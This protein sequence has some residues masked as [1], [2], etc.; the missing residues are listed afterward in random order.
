MFDVMLIPSDR[1]TYTLSSF[2]T[3]DKLS[4]F[5]RL[6]HS[7]G[8]AGEDNQS[9]SGGSEELGEDSRRLRLRGLVTNL[10][11]RTFIARLIGQ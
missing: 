8:H 5:S 1:K 6:W 7:R 3:R 4:S 10:W 9:S 2:I 11:D